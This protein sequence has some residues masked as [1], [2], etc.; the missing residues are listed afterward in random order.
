MDWRKVGWGL[1]ITILVLIFFQGA[2]EAAGTVSG[3][4]GAISTFFNSL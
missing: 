1:A 3:A 4:A 2:E